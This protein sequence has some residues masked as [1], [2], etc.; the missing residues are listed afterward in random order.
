MA[1]FGVAAHG[2]G[3]FV[4]SLLVRAL[5]CFRDLLSVVFGALLNIVPS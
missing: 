5:A 2:G 1:A 4:V 3:L